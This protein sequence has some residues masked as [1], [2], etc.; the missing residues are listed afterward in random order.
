MKQE[1]LAE[2]RTRLS[3]LPREDIE[4]RL[5]FYGE[6]IDDRIEDGIPEADAVAEIGSIDDIVAQILAEYPLSR[7]VRERVRPKRTLRAWEITLLILG[8]P[9]WLSLLTAAFAVLLCVYIVL[10]SLVISLWAVELSL[11]ISGLAT[12]TAAVVLAAEGQ[13]LMGLA[14]LGAG[15]FLAG[16]SVFLF[17]GCRAATKGAVLLTK[18]IAFGIKKLFIGRDKNEQNG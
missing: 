1:F 2:L 17:F 16:L 11:A 6:M 10:W 15:F 14:F 12:A 4:E 18:K 13:G 7:I 9:I 3:G 5:G 8:S